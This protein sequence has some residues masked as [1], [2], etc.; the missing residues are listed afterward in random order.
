LIET[1]DGNVCSGLL[2]SK[3][4]QEITIRDKDRKEH[5]FETSEVENIIPQRKSLMPDLLLRDMSAQQVADLL[6][7][8]ESLK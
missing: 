6:T 1:L 5:R 8:L 3:T 2:V 7:W 4:E